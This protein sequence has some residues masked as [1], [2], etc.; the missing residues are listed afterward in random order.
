MSCLGQAAIK[1]PL[2]DSVEQNMINSNYC[3]ILDLDLIHM[4][5]SDV[6]YSNVYKLKFNRYDRVH[7]LVAWFD[8]HFSNLQNPITLSTSPFGRY[9]HWKQVVFYLDHEL[10]V[11][12]GDVLQGSIAVRK[13]KANFRELDI[14]ISYHMNAP[15][16]QRDFV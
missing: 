16:C 9:T 5:A 1:E 10:K 15:Q 6:E 11:N 8:V 7:A 13:S 12:E 3:M 4:K 14:K 2:V